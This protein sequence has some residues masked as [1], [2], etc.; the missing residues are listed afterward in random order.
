MAR[1]KKAET[2]DEPKLTK[3]DFAQEIIDLGVMMC[4]DIQE[5]RLRLE[6]SMVNAITNLYN[7]LKN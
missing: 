4:R 2:V 5:G 7:S 3:D 6:D 1:P